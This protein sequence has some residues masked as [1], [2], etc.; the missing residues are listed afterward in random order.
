MPGLRFLFTVVVLLL[1]LSALLVGAKEPIQHVSIVHRHGARDAPPLIH[2]GFADVTQLTPSGETMMQNLGKLLRVTYDSFISSYDPDAY[3]VFSEDADNCIQSAHGVLQAFC[4]S[5]SPFFPI[6]RHTPMETDWLM[7]FNHML[8]NMYARP[9]W[10]FSY[11]NNDTLAR[12]MLS[13]AE[14]QTLSSEFGSWC[15]ET[16]MQCALFAADALQSRITAG[17]VSTQLQAVFKA[18]LLPLSYGD[19]KHKFGFHSTDPYAVVGSPAYSLTAKVLHDAATGDKKVCQYSVHDYAILGVLN[20]LGGI[21]LDDIDPKWLPRFGAVL[22]V[23]SYRNG[24]VSFSYAEPQQEAGS[25][26]DYV[27]GLLPITVHCQT[28]EGSDYV[29]STCP[30][31]DV[32]RH[33]NRSKPTMADPFCY[34]RPEDKCDILDAVPSAHC[35]YY[36]K[37]CPNEVCGPSAE[38]DPSRNY[39]CVSFSK[40]KLMKNYLLAF[41]L[42]GV[43]GAVVG[44]AIGAFIALLLRRTES[45]EEHRRLVLNAEA[46]GTTA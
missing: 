29:A 5:S 20:V 2:K 9:Q 13:T 12:A 23:T 21:Q 11:R 4:Y 16:P 35:Q 28:A 34:L 25:R 26:L 27:S 3:D 42:A 32:W 10:F 7:G 8:P 14:L 22:T 33:V 40:R 17:N 38:L 44:I 19:N 41:I 37:Y 31:S 15:T 18:K 6:V 45:R 36:R 30:L 46:G 1:L 43:V 24:N 39:T